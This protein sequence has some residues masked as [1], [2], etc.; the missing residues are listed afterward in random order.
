M[1]RT[2]VL[3][4]PDAVQRGLLGRIIGR[5]EAKGL[6]IVG[7]KMLAVP[8]PAARAMYAEHEAKD[9]HAPLLAFLASGPSVA[10]VVEGLEAITVVRRLLGATNAREAAPGTV[11]GDLAMSRRHNL[12]HG[13][14]SPASAERE[15]DLF[16]RS[17]ELHDYDLTS[18]GWVYD[19]LEDGRRT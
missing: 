9:F 6:K 17:D 7:V 4:K 1:E 12:A 5:I 11:R 2:L 18:D 14:D 16:F 13:S 19:R 10:M 8:D 3:L 15:I